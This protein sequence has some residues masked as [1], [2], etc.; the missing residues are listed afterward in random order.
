MSDPIPQ[1]Q[2]SLIEYVNSK[3][4]RRMKRQ[5]SI[6]RVCAEVALELLG[7]GAESTLVINCCSRLGYALGADKVECL[8][9]ANGIVVTTIKD[10]QSMTTMRRCPSQGVNFSV[11]LQL[12]RLVI[13]IEEHG[14]TPAIVQ[15]QLSHIHHKRYDSLFVAFMVA[16]SCAC[17]SRLSGGD[18]MVMLV[19]FVAA[20]VGIRVRQFMHKLNFN[21]FAIFIA[22]A[23]SA[24]LVT[25]AAFRYNLGNDPH[26]AVASAVLLL[27]PG[28]PLVNAFS[29]ILKGH[30]NVGFGRW[31]MATVM[32]LGACIGMALAM[33]VMN[34]N[35]QE[36]IYD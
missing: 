21:V 19:T 6:T 14:G 22:S 18:V 32:A 17:F 36:M 26:Y 4:Q 34:I 28:V 10:N 33:S 25:T 1:K 29:D 9:T 7:N 31:I 23:F 35:L 3:E 8:L 15:Q 2:L 24:T 30:N 16:L 13:N 5:R 20:F 27:V 12:Q 11:V